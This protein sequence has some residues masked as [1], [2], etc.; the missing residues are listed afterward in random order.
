MNSNWNFTI[1]ACNEIFKSIMLNSL[2]VNIWYVVD[3]P[4]RKPHW[5]CRISLS[6]LRYEIADTSRSVIPCNQSVQVDHLSYSLTLLLHFRINTTSC[7]IFL[8]ISSPHPSV[9]KPLPPSDLSLN[10][11]MAISTSVYLQALSLF[12]LIVPSHSL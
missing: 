4:V 1:G 7:C 5:Y 10:F 11:W 6:I 12:H 8:Y 2:N 9:C 3:L